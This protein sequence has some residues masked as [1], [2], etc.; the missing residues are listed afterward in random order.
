[1]P[2][3]TAA[4]TLRGEA[5]ESLCGQGHE[6]GDGREVPVGVGDLGVAQI[7]GQVRHAV[8]DVGAL[9]VPALHAPHDE[10]VPQILKSRKT[11]PSLGGPTEA[12]S[13]AR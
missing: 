9:V 1:M 2:R 11:R 10:C 3:W 4:S 8:V 6:L 13:G 12:P 7:G 5:L